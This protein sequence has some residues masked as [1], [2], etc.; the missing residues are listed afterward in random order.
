[1]PMMAVV[2]IMQSAATAPN[3]ISSLQNNVPRVQFK[4]TAYTDTPKVDISRR[5]SQ[6]AKHTISSW[7]TALNQ[8]QFWH[9]AAELVEST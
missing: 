9:K 2:H 1:M 8:S 7:T 4:S 3:T 6:T 5:T